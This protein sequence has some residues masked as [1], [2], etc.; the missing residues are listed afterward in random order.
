MPIGVPIATACTVRMRLPTIGLSRPPA[1]PGGGVICVNT[2]SDS[3]LKPCHNSAARIKTSQPRP[4]SVAASDS[5][6]A[7]ALL[8]RRLM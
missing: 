2:A 1:A 3:P 5:T 7:M 6:I 4:K 8:R